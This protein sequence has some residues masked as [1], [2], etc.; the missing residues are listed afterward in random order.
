MTQRDERI[1]LRVSA[2]LNTL[3]SRAAAYS[4]MSL[5]SFLISVASDHT[6]QVIG[7]HETVTLSSRDWKAF[8]GALDEA[9][10]P[11]PI[12]RRRSVLP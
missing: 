3:L 8:L 10:Q 9:D 7:E 12:G 4:G 6:K 11:R 1:D 2:D 5:S